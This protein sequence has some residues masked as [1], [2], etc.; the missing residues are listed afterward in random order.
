[1]GRCE[2]SSMRTVIMLAYHFPP[3]GGV[4]VMRALRFSRYLQA[5]GYRPVVVSVEPSSRLPEPRDPG[6]LAELPSDLEVHRVPCLEPDNY[7]DSWDFPADKIRRNLFKTFDFLLVPDDRALWIRPAARK[8]EKLA[9][10]HRADLIW[11]TAQ[12]FS[13]LLAGLRAS[14]ASG[15]PLVADFRD[16]WTTSNADFRRNEPARQ[17]KEEAMESALLAHASAVVSV[18]PGIVEALGRRCPDPAK[19]HLLVNGFDPAHFGQ[20]AKAPDKFRLVHAG[21][22]Y[23]HRNPQVLFDI[24]RGLPEELRNQLECLFLGRVDRDSE[25][26]FASAPAQVKSLGFQAHSVVRAHMQ[27]ADLNLLLLENV[28]TV[29]WLYTG[30]VFEYLGARRPILM[31]GP[32]HSPLADLVR[33]SGLGRC[34]EWTDTAGIGADILEAWRERAHPRPPCEE[35]IT[36]YDARQQTRQLAELFDH[37]LEARS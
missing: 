10:R 12:P 32:V 22:I 2:A 16:D 27:S 6:L 7:A 9:K 18:T 8:A 11:A 37:V 35:V 21:G 30:K 15:V 24:L 14:R 25:A 19:V 36:R 20:Q 3:L 26:I 29:N 31:L 34:R 1:M 23:K 33:E 4:A 13:T 17:K 28:P 5:F